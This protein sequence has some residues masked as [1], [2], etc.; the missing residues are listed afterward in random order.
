[1][2]NVTSQRRIACPYLF[3]E[4]NKLQRNGI[5]TFS[6][7]GQ[8]LDIEFSDQIDSMAGVEYYNG[9]LIPG[10]VNAHC[11]LELSFFKGVLKQHTGLVDF[12]KHVVGCRGSYPWDVQVRRAQI[13]SRVMYSDGVQAVGDISNTTASFQ[14]KAESPII[15]HTFAEYF[16]MPTPDQAVESYAESTQNIAEANRL[17]LTITPTPHSTY[18]VSDALFK[19]GGDS[20]RLSIHFMETPSEVDYFERRGGMYDFVVG[21]GME[22]DFLNYGSHSRRL[23]ESLPGNIPLLLIHNTQI[24]KSDVE[25]ILSHFN[26]VTF[27]LCP[28]SNY[29]IESAY[30]P[31]IMLRDMGCRVALGTDSLS[32]N[33][34]LSMAA[35]IV[36]LANANPEL[37]L[38]TILE[39]ATIS[40]AHGLGMGNE[41]GSFTVGKR[42]GAVLLTDID[43]Q[44]MRP[45]QATRSRRL[46]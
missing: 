17:G 46:L 3:T 7:Q 45:T 41:I 42:P 15:Y 6:D 14:A 5:V 27:V 40:G 18:L 19:M 23:V 31:A 39:W 38:E 32:S 13:E 24:Q 11:H 9:I 21:G 10:M 28:R 30:P 22:P 26:D 25:L 34:S 33:T 29:F 12:I 35:E 4:H 43:F 37:K 2:K 1:M 36:W 8:V 20:E 16:G 44:T